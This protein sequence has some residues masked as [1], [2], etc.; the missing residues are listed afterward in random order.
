MENEGYKVVQV[1][2]NNVVLATHMNKEKI[3]IQKGLG[4]GCRAGQLIGPES[5]FEKVFTIENDEN[6]EK[7]KQLITKVDDELVGLCEEI[8]NLIDNEVEQTLN[9]VVHIR[10]VDH[11]AFM[12]SRVKQNDQIENPFMVEIET[13]FPKEVSIAEKVIRTLEQR[14][15][16]SIPYDEVGFIAL[17]INS[18]YNKGKIS[19]TI[20]YAYI[21]NSVVELIEDEFHIEVARNSID[22]ARFITH[23][24][25][26]L[27][28][29]IKGIPLKNGLLSSIKRTYKDSFKVARK[30]G[31]I[32]EEEIDK[33]VS[34]EE[35]GYITVH[36]ERLR[37]SITC[38][39]DK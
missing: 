9:E 39:E 5:R 37:N 30:I 13:L 27:D 32:I 7:F 4:F 23:I 20:K 31:K 24:K 15:G 33:K 26:A 29:I 3:I 36:I 17:H 25:F 19:N 16:I 38:F 12:V 14:L 22:Y 34:E 6:T 18:A 28:R 2:N 1:F 21:A 35:I 11:I 8:I 10:L